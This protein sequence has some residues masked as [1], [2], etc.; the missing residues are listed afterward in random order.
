LMVEVRGSDG[1]IVRNKANSSIADCGFTT[2]PR[3]DTASRPPPRHRIC[4]RGTK[5]AKQSQF[6]SPSCETKPISGRRAGWLRQTK[7]I[8]PSVKQRA[9]TWWI[10][11]YGELNMLE[12]SVKQ[13]QFQDAQAQ[14][15]ARTATG[16]TG[17]ASC[18]SKA[19]LQDGQVRVGQPVSPVGLVV[20]TRPISASRAGT[21]GRNV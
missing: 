16:S 1:P 14:P 9:S 13:S 2:D 15:R 17:G 11:N 12:V 7:P 18:T 21:G 8:P 10:R 3:R 6:G 20:Q 5:C 4:R 19:N